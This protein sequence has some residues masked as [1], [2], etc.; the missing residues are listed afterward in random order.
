MGSS[1][2]LILR[3]YTII[4][5]F[6]TL[7]YFFVS[8]TTYIIYLLA[9]VGPAYGDFAEV[10]CDTKYKNNKKMVQA[11]IENHNV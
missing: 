8:S 6:S 4:G 11:S 7:E 10:Y 1:T 2:F 5:K 9:A 3:E